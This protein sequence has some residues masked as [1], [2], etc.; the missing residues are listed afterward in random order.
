MT[1]KM[2]SG[3][4]AFG[5]GWLGEPIKAMLTG[6]VET[7][8]LEPADLTQKKPV[9]CNTDEIMKKDGNAT[10]AKIL[11]YIYA[12]DPDGTLW[13]AIT[14]VA[15]KAFDDM[16]EKLKEKEIDLG[17]FTIPVINFPV[18][19]KFSLGQILDLVGAG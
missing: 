14:A 3:L 16:K 2:F 17:T 18:H 5:F 9:L 8:G 12:I 11:D 19:L 1:D 6:V 7:L 13:D 4:E 10:T 15:G